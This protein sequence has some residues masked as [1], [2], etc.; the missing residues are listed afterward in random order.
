[1]DGTKVKDKDTNRIHKSAQGDTPLSHRTQNIARSSAASAAPCSSA[2]R[3]PGVMPV[4]A[5]A[6]A[7]LPHKTLSIQ[8]QFQLFANEDDDED[9]SLKVHPPPTASPRRKRSLTRASVHQDQLLFDTDEHAKLLKDMFEARLSKGRGE[10]L[11]EI[12]YDGLSRRRTIH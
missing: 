1:M 12:G 2:A 10:T 5:A 6:A 9:I 11:F 3:A 8:Q 4:P 7:E